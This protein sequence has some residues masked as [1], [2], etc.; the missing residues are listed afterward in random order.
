M[1]MHRLC[2]GSPHWRQ[3]TGIKTCA[4]AA[5][6]MSVLAL[7]TTAEIAFLPPPLIP[8]WYCPPPPPPS[9]WR[10][11]TL[12]KQESLST[13]LFLLAQ[14]VDHQGKLGPPLAVNHIR[15]FQRPPPGTRASDMSSPLPDPPP[16]HPRSSPAAEIRLFPKPNAPPGTAR[17]SQCA[18]LDACYLAPVGRANA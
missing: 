17:T 16:P 12:A 18:R 13:S 14:A 5:S 4:L 9:W 7:G 2:V 15:L 11:S 3:V 10:L 1:K 6:T 8:A